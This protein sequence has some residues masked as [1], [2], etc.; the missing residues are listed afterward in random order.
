MPN[1]AKPIN[2]LLSQFL[3]WLLLSFT[4]MGLGACKTTQIPAV[5]L[6]EAKR[7]TANFKAGFVPPPKTIADI[8]RILEQQKW[9][10]LERLEEMRL[11][12]DEKPPVTRD[13][14]ELAKFY[15]NRGETADH[16]GRGNQALA[17]YHKAAEQFRLSNNH[18]MRS[19]VIESAAYVTYY[20]GNY[21]DSI[22]GVRKSI[23]IRG[24][25]E[26]DNVAGHLVVAGMAAEGGDFIL[27]EQT[28]KRTRPLV[29]K[30]RGSIYWS[31]R[32]KAS[33][34]TLFY[35][36]SGLV[37]A[38][39][40]KLDD[41]EVLLRNAVKDWE[42][43]KNSTNQGM[44]SNLSAQ[45]YSW[46]LQHYAVVL[47]AQGRYVEAELA[48]RESL[49]LMLSLYGRYSS[50][51]A[52]ALDV[53]TKALI[54]QGRYEEAG[55]LAEIS[56][57]IYQD[58]GVQPDSKMLNEARGNMADILV[59]QGKWEK[60]LE[61]FTQI[62]QDLATDLPTFEMYFSLNLNWVL[63]Q[64]NTGNIEAA[65]TIAENIHERNKSLL[66]ENHIATAE[67]LGF[68]ATVQAYEGRDREALKNFSLAVPILLSRSRQMQSES[69]SKRGRDQRLELILESYIG[70]LADIR[71]TALETGI[72]AVSEAFRLAE[73]LRG[74]SVQRALAASSVRA[75]AGNPELADLARREQ[76][77]QK[78]VA[79][80]W[81]LLNEVMN[82]PEDQRSEAQTTDLRTRIDKLRS[83]RAALMEEIESRFPEYAELINPKPPTL[84]YVQQLLANDEALISI[85]TGTNRSYV[86]AMTKKDG[87]AFAAVDMGRA[88][89]DDTV[90][91]LRA[92]LDS[93]AE[94]L[95]DIPEF[96]LAE[97]HHLYT[98]LLKP[99]EAGWKTAKHL[100]VVAHGSLGY[101][102][103]AL[104]PTDKA[105]L[106]T[107]S[108]ALF[109]N[110]KEVPWL[111]RTHSVTMLPSVASL[112]TLRNLPMGDPQRRAFL[113]FGDPWFN[114]E[115]A[116]EAKSNLK[117]ETEVAAVK[118]R[119]LKTRGRY[120][121][122]RSRPETRT[123]DSAGIGVLP[124]LPDTADEVRSMA[125]A[126]DADLTQDVFLGDKASEGNVKGTNL[127]GYQVISFAT[128]GLLSGDID[129]LTQPA[130]ALSAPDV[131]NDPNNDGLLTL[132]EIIALRLDADWVVL[133]ACNTGSGES[134]DAEALSGLGRAF[135]YAG[136]RA[137]LVSNWP[138]ETTSA[139]ALT[140]EL[141]QRVGNTGLPRGEALRQAMVSLIDSPGY[142]D[143]DTGSVVFSYA[144]PIFWS[145][146]SLVGDGGAQN[147]PLN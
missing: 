86:W 134:S 136:T 99:V 109:S 72:D 96:N 129:G 106:N 12:A 125:V 62:E 88:D 87:T 2:K 44:D 76:D 4:A 130:L 14:D 139:R 142:I 19:N 110:Y 80:L 58:V 54:E 143:Q 103:L 95:G 124:R 78:Q 137:L 31:P 126:L 1:P 140:T 70:L 26:E 51:A 64:I 47:I 68:M 38:A 63:A 93:S 133:S 52:W 29:N 118:S 33:V 102:P 41:A 84:S 120:L 17:D 45:Q 73:S 79:T 6:D 131:A 121:R 23:E 65:A 35:T 24:G 30:V 100:S 132:G 34:Q 49:L 13:P 36:A 9:K 53:L 128:H 11:V 55:K 69:S 32:S 144:H 37:L 97:A 22:E 113:G 98:K 92:A 91:L 67:A 21:S 50:Y 119:G 20:F 146:F 57:Q 114:L 105:K 135:F 90:D 85:Y 116:N 115:Q 145:P 40:G 104:L 77:T 83:A 82:R 81:G 46:Y 42:P 15:Y 101:L 3:L 43:Y 122:L 5:S 147:K 107:K 111:A 74:R 48:A 141:F 117:K 61:I 138:V 123:L 66:G 60:A 10:D 7:V 56:I 18:K 28:L 112:K 127:A 59:S 39:R 75:A 71:G 16:L 94:T 8:T 89:L 108:G 25:D 27:A